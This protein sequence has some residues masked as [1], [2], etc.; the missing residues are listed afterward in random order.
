MS[1]KNERLINL[2]IALLATKRYLTKNEIFR[3][4]EG[5]EGNAE[6]KERMFERDKDDLRKL[7]IQIEVGGLDPLFDDEAGYRIKPESYALSLRNLSA[8]QVTLLSLAAQAWQ[9]AAF[10]DISEQALRKFTSI[11]VASDSSQLPLLAPRLIGADDNLRTALDAL[12]SLTPIKFDY[13]S[14]DGT[15]Q[16]RQLE[17]YGVQ[18]R[19]SNWYLIGRDSE[20]STIRNFRLDRIKGEIERSGKAQ[21]YEI[22]VNFEIPE[23]EPSINQAI[24]SLQVR[25]G[26]GYQLRRLAQTI[27]TGDEWDLLEIPFYDLAFM[28][29]LILWHG[30]D[31]IVSA[32]AELRTAIIAALESVVSSHA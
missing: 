11:G 21:S 9:D 26:A 30:E 31:V 25:P 15:L 16:N 1:R 19:K 27:E 7:G 5:Y 2:T 24:A 4:V 13:L 6:S 3:S 29:N 18:A 8:T 20:K 22:P 32:P 23:S 14:A 10:T 28:K 17:V 12:T